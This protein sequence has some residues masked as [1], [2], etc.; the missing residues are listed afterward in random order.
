MMD[1]KIL[2][3]LLDNMIKKAGIIAIENMESNEEEIPDVEFSKEHNEKMEEIFKKARR[4]EYEAKMRRKA[5]NRKKVIV[6][7]AATVSIFAFM[8]TCVGAMREGGLAK[9][10]FDDKT[11]YSEVRKIRDIDNMLKVDNVY[12][13]YVPSGF[14][15]EVA[16]NSSTS[17]VIYLENGDNYIVLKMKKDKW[18]NKINTESGEIEDLII[19]NKDMTYWENENEK[20]ISWQENGYTFVLTTN[21]NKSILLD[22]A[23]E[24]KLMEV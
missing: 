7:L 23:K 18:N 5:A 17:E 9:Y 8:I 19:N 1:E 24:I 12:F 20:F 4:L 11:E 3:K 2:E 6:L 10:F 22:I 21:C 13:G 16:N 14:K 15:Y